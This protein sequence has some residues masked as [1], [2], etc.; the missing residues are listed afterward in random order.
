MKKAT[1]R[2][3]SAALVL[4]ALALCRPAV[5]GELTQ[6]RL[7]ARN[8]ALLDRLI[9]ESGRRAPGHDRRPRPYIVCDWDNTSA[10]GDAAE[11]LTW[12][13]A[14]N[15]AYPFSVADFRRT[16]GLN[17]PK[18]A[19]KLAND[20]G[21]PIVFDDLVEDLVEDYAFL[22][23]SYKGLGGTRSLEEVRATEE[24]RDFVAKLFVLFDAL[25]ATVGTGRADQWQGQLMT[26]TSSERLMELSEK[27][28][29]KNLGAEIRKIRLSSSE[30][31]TR[32][33]TRVSS[34][35]SQ[36]LRIYPDMGYL[37]QALMEAGIDVYIVSAS[38]EEII[39]P[40][41]CKEEFGY[42]IPRDHVF[43]AKF[44]KVGG[45]LQPELSPER[46]MTWG[47]GKVELIKKLILPRSGQPPLL[48]C[49]DSDGDFDMFTAFPGTKLGFIV[50]RLKKG[51]IG[52]V[53]Q[54]AVRQLG[55]RKPR[56]V[57]QGVDENTGLFDADEATVKFGTTEK[58][59]IR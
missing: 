42:G 28:I 24:F 4:F 39:V 59:L 7:S 9:E 23:S 5:A 19:S 51:N 17:V 55:E 12:Y 25:D 26:G 3:V 34:T 21:K 37:Y 31:L 48:V 16:V 33:C 32:R 13:M 27:S 36:G 2:L 58:V 44:A 22:H 49:G 57:L 15:L 35:T 6:G 53:C 47:P 30:T 50:N 38:P 43:G 54:D 8:H 18:G 14:E 46:A 29:R 1:S 45:V 56:Y 10:F 41:I 52:T 20:D 11:T 40:V